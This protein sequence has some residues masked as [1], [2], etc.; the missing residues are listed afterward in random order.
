M[1]TIII[2]AFIFL[3]VNLPSYVRKDFMKLIA[4]ESNDAKNNLQTSQLNFLSKIEWLRFYPLKKLFLGI[5]WLLCLFIATRG[6]FMTFNN[7]SK[8]F[9]FLTVLF[10]LITIF[11]ARKIYKY[12]RLPFHCVPVLNYTKTKGELKESLQGECFEKVVFE[13]KML[14]KYFYVLIS[15]NWAII[16]GYL[17]PR[18]GIEKIYYLHPS[19]I[20]NHEQIR[21]IYSNGEEFRLPSSRET[22]NELRQKE[23]SN[24]LHK[25]SPVVI[26][27]DE[28]EASTSI[29]KD[30]SIIYWKMNY[31]GKFRRTLW[32]IPVVIVLCFLTPLFMGRFWI[33]YDIILIAV[34]VWQLWYTYKM[35]KVEEEVQEKM[36]TGDY[37]F[38]PHCKKVVY[39]DEIICPHCHSDVQ[40]E[41]EI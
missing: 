7:P 2:I 25:I 11:T 24:L 31:K 33:I 27:E 1:Y 4:D 36:K 21:F 13:H 10:W 20:A 28:Y 15:E 16:D 26:E 40:E 3:A 32:F 12:I 9:I 5:F 14:S 8:T 29:K 23:I 19:P 18:H 34:L 17:I 35:K 39:K 6:I 37:I 30:K 22:A 41:H 38:C